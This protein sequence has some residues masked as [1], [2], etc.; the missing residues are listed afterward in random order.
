MPAAKEKSLPMQEAPSPCG[1]LKP[2][3]HVSG[4]KGVT[5]PRSCPRST[6]NIFPVPGGPAPKQN[7]LS[8]EENESLAIDSVTALGHPH[9]H[10]SDTSQPVRKDIR[11][12]KPPLFRL[13]G[14]V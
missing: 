10:L 11:C 3:Y 5:R 14:E 9:F 12:G 8:R 4:K 13:P 1:V 2:C 6:P 7:L